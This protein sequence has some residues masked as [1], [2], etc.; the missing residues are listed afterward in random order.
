MRQEEKFACEE[1]IEK[2]EEEGGREDSARLSIDVQGGVFRGGLS[3]GGGGRDDPGFGGDNDYAISLETL[4]TRG[5]LGVG[6]EAE[7]HQK[8]AKK[9]QEKEHEKEKW[10]ERNLPLREAPGVAA[11]SRGANA[12]DL[13]AAADDEIPPDDFTCCSPAWGVLHL[14]GLPKKKK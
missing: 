4:T 1:K 5:S 14:V 6:L 10:L 3:G 2:K 7:A 12:R 11:S 13:E 8:S 9:E